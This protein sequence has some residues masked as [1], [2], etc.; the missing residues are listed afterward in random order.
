M[1]YAAGKIAITPGLVVPLHIQ[2][3]EEINESEEIRYRIRHILH[4]DAHWWHQTMVLAICEIP[5]PF[6]Y[7]WMD[8]IS[9]FVPRGHVKS[10]QWRHIS[11]DAY[12]ITGTSTITD[13]RFTWTPHKRPVIQGFRR[14]PWSTSKTTQFKCIV[15]VQKLYEIICKCIFITKQKS[16]NVPKQNTI[17][18]AV[19]WHLS[20]DNSRVI[21]KDQGAFQKHLR[22]LKSK[23]CKIF[24]C[25]RNLNLSMHG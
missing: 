6:R 18:G 21:S 20:L 25:E 4:S 7:R 19:W 9:I 11:S 16:Y 2:E 10:L 24:A 15:Y 3:P 8:R 1:G 12:Q 5:K 13:P 23:R 22:T 14:F 17:E